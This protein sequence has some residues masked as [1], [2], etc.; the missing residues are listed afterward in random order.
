MDRDKRAVRVFT[1]QPVVWE[2]KVQGHSESAAAA[3]RQ[4]TVHLASVDG[5]LIGE[6]GPI[7]REVESVRRVSL[8]PEGYPLPECHTLEML[9]ADRTTSERRLTFRF[10]SRQAVLDKGASRPRRPG[11]VLDATAI[12]L[13]VAPYVSVKGTGMFP[14]RALCEA[15]EMTWD[16]DD[17]EK[18]LTFSG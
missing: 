15:F 2:A 13:P 10:G 8:N 7:V 5:V 6:T 12:E 18:L 14:V 9:S 11:R 3:H 4:P 17:T 16:Y 1:G